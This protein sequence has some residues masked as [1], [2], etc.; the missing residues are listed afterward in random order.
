MAQNLR[1][2]GNGTLGEVDGLRIGTGS[3]APDRDHTGDGD[4]T[5][6][7]YTWSA[8]MGLDTTF[9]KAVYSG[10]MEGVQ[11]ICPEGWRLPSDNDWENLASYIANDLGK[12]AKE[13][14]DWL[15]I[16][17][18]LKTRR[19]WNVDGGGLDTYGFSAAPAGR[20]R[21]GSL[22][23][24]NVMWEASFWS[25]EQDPPMFEGYPAASAWHR[26]ID[27]NGLNTKFQKDRSYKTYGFSVRCVAN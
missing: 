3:Y 9:D 10:P 14:D 17:P 6:I 24:E 26:T 23:F 12:T 5:G 13:D 18:Y 4:F 11:G 1:Y 19:G 20:Y 27:L 15:E 25:T 22:A 21:Q 7:F 8:A 2:D 16:G